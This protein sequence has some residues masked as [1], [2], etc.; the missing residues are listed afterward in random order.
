MCTSQNLHDMYLK[1]LVKWNV[2][3]GKCHKDD[4]HNF[5]IISDF[6]NRSKLVGLH[7]RCL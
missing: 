6:I 7:S 2:L 1:F 4:I 5:Y 3:M